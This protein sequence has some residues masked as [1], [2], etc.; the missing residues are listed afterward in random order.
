[1]ESLGVASSPQTPQQNAAMDG[2]GKGNSDQDATSDLHLYR[3][4]LCSY[5]NSVL[6]LGNA[7]GAD[8][9]VASPIELRGQLSI[10][11]NHEL[12]LNDVQGEVFDWMCLHLE[13]K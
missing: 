9:S 12:K 7:S 2:D 4:F 11:G 8:P 1:M 13:Q 3:N 5:V 6:S 10:I